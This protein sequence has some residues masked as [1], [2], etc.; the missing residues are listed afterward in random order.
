VEEQHIEEQP[1]NQKPDE[2]RHIEEQPQ[3][4]PAEQSTE[5]TMGP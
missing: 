4:H 5:Q 1:E 3:E 2:E